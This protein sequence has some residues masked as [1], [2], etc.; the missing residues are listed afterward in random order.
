MTLHYSMYIN[1]PLSRKNVFTH[2]VGLIDFKIE[3]YPLKR[4]RESL[5]SDK[6]IVY[7]DV[8]YQ[9][10]V[11]SCKEYG[12]TPTIELDFAYRDTFINDNI[13]DS[14]IKIVLLLQKIEGDVLVSFNY[15][16]L[17]RRD[18]HTIVCK[19]DWTPELREFIPKPCKL[20][21]VIDEITV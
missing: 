18:G 11:D 9:W 7:V 16:I 2:L 19:D 1:T 13:Y 20:V 10:D 3:E 14:Q 12:I 15:P 8:P 4:G 17:L 6:Y 21:D 5:S